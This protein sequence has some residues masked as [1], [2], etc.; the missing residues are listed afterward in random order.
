MLSL[1][2]LY[3]CVRVCMSR[4]CQICQH[5]H[6][7]IYQDARVSL[8]W[9]LQTEEESMRRKIKIKSS[10]TDTK[11]SRYSSQNC[12]YLL[13]WNCI[14]NN[15]SCTSPVSKRDRIGQHCT[16]RGKV[17]QR[18]TAEQDSGNNVKIKRERRGKKKVSMTFLNTVFISQHTHFHGNDE[19][20]RQWTYKLNMIDSSAREHTDTVYRL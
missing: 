18:R 13:P 2:V 14:Q 11:R 20:Q 4:D 8:I 10:C 5:V 12:A 19:I 6:G 17:R 3:V 7:N 15:S 1:V 16:E 9:Q